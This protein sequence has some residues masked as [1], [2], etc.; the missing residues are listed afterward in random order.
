MEVTVRVDVT[1]LLETIRP[2]LLDTG[3]W[4]NVIGYIRR[5]GGDLAGGRGEGTGQRIGREIGEG[6]RQRIGEDEREQGNADRKVKEPRS[7]EKTVQA[8]VLWSAGALR[9][10][11]YEKIVEQMRADAREEKER[12]RD[13]GWL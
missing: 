8:T 6:E 11:E 9:V 5:D 4:V 3:S 7:K 10:E 2:E 1:L 13:V 12:E